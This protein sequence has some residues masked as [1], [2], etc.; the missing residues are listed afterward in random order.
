[1]QM[2]QYSPNTTKFG[3]F[4]LRHSTDLLSVNSK[5]SRGVSFKCLALTECYHQQHLSNNPNI[6]IHQ[7]EI[8]KQILSSYTNKPIQAVISTMQNCIEMCICDDG[9][10]LDMRHPNY[11]VSVHTFLN[12]VEMCNGSVSQPPTIERNQP[13]TM[14]PSFLSLLFP[15]FRLLFSPFRLMNE[16]CSIKPTCARIQ[17]ETFATQ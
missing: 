7:N 2:T 11:T 13:T 17:S 4:K 12:R 8:P 15:S 6:S 1:M 3:H 10:M 14:L 9:Q 16:Y 5:Y